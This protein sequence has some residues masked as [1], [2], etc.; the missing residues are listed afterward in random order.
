MGRSHE[1]NF[2]PEI[3]DLPVITG[4]TT[5]F[6]TAREVNDQVSASLSNGESLYTLDEA[7]IR[8][9]K[10][11]V[12]LTQDICSVC[13]IDLVT[14]ERLAA[15]MEP[16]P[17]VHSLNPESIDGVLKSILEVGAAVTMETEA[18][19]AHDRLIDRMRKVDALVGA[20]RAKHATRPPLSVAF[21][22]WPD[23]IFVG[24]H[25]T[26][27]LIAQAGGSHPLNEATDPH[28]DGA[29]KSFAVDEQAVV[30]SSPDLVIISPCG[31][32]LQATRREA[33]RLEAQPWFASLPAVQSGRVALVDGDAMFNRP[34]PR[35]VDALEWL[36]SVIMELPELAPRG[37]PAEW[38]HG[39][40]PARLVA[41]PSAGTRS[42]GAPSVPALVDI[43]AAHLCA[44]RAGHKTYIDPITRY[45]VFTQLASEE[46]GK[47]CGSGCRHC[48]Y[49]HVK[50][51]EKR[52]AKLPRPILV[53]PGER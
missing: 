17:A 53:A 7:R 39:V 15:S 1:D 10:P 2:P 9:L 5:T 24:G 30:D 33:A 22:E 51:P 25:W 26:P 6:T 29:G 27:Q 19:E 44:V 11:D 12:I 42:A 36:A 49:D 4:Q 14:V 31:L 23:P 41:E 13:A 38:L 34:G 20:A 46:R 48:A 16:R 50:V 45:T 3:T 28:G 43:E 18:R 8:E 52:R 47:C 32:D 35:L 37:F 40:Q 21:I